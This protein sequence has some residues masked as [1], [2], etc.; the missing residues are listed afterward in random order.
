MLDLT[1]SVA[2]ELTRSMSIRIEELVRE[3]EQLRM[4]LLALESSAGVP[5]PPVTVPPDAEA[6]PI[7]EDRSAPTERPWW[8][9]WFG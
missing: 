5:Q 1:R 3:N 7:V 8:R 6:T 9:R 2:N 4:R